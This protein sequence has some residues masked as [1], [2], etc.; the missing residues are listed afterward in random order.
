MK[1]FEVPLAN[2]LEQLLTLFSYFIFS[3]VLDID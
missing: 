1:G 3:F 2:E